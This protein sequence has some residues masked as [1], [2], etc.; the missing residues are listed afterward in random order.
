M[1]PGAGWDASG[2]GTAATPPY[3]ASSAWRSPVPYLFGGLAAMLGLIAFALLV[4]FCS[5]RQLSGFLESGGEANG[6]PDSDEEAPSDG[7]DATKPPLLFEDSIV[8]IMAGDRKPTFLATPMSS[9]AAS[10]TDKVDEAGNDGKEAGSTATSPRSILESNRRQN[11]LIG[12]KYRDSAVTLVTPQCF[13]Y[14]SKNHQHF[15]CSSRVQSSCYEPPSGRTLRTLTWTNL[16]Y[17]TS[18]SRNTRGPTWLDL[19]RVDLLL[20]L[21][22]SCRPKPA[23]ARFKRTNISLFS[24]QTVCQTDKKPRGNIAVKKLKSMNSKAE[25]EF[26]VEVE[27]LARVRHKNLL[28]LRG[29]CVVTDQRLI[30]YD[31]MPNLSLVSH[32]HGQYAHEVRLD[33]RRRMNVIL[34]SAEALV[35]LHHEVTPHIIHRDIKA[36][37]V[38]LDANFE[39]LVADFGFAKL[40]PE[41]VSHMTTRVKGTL[42]YL[43]PEY[44]MWGRVSDSCDVY[45]FGILLLELVSGRKPIEKLP[46][47]MK[48]TITEWAEPLISKGRFREVVDPRLRGNFD[49]DELRRVVEAAV[50]CIQGEAEQR[51][52]MKEVVGILMGREV[53]EPKMEAVRLKSIRYGEHLTTMDQSSDEGFDDSVDAGVGGGGRGGSVGDESGLY[54]VFGAMEVQK[55]HDPY[56]KHAPSAKILVGVSLDARASFQLLSWA[57]TVAAHPNDTVVALHV[58]GAVPV[59][60]KD[61]PRKRHRSRP[62]SLF[63]VDRGIRRPKEA[64]IHATDNSSSSS[65]WTSNH[66]VRAVSPFHKLFCSIS[67]PER[68]HSPRESICEK[69][70]PRG[71]LEGPDA[72]SPVVAEDCSS[73]PSSVTGRRSSANMWR[74]SSVMKLLFSLPRSSGESISKES[75]A[76]SSYTDDLKP[77][78][79]CFTYEEISRGSL[80]NGR[81]VAVKRLTKGNGD[82]QKEKEFL[83]ELGILGHVCHPNAANLIGCCI[84]NGLH[85]VFDLSC[86]GSLASAL[87]SEASAS[88][89]SSSSSPSP[90]HRIIHR[91][92]K[93]SNVLLGPDLEPQISDFGLAKWLPKQWT[94]HSVIP[95]EGTFGYLA[96]EYFMHGIVDEKTDVFAFGV[97]L[98]EIVTGRRPVDAS[99]QNLLLW[100]TPLIESGR[101]AELADPK[102][103]DE[104]DKSQL[105]RLVLTAS[106]CV[107]QSS[108]W[109]PSMGE[110]SE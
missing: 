14:Y 26:A 82:R 61:S 20:S 3:P 94:H 79:R 96:P 38:L 52:D 87:H 56:A 103:E 46:G 13:C 23:Q 4:L 74:R 88:A 92:I 45:S 76:C 55:M 72:G 67:K 101:I 59:W 75:D 57:V 71:V 65:R 19:V 41:G 106:Y 29:Y 86:N 70:S 8:V 15:E 58:L 24:L 35:Y 5:F 7:G 43:A 84:E 39:P 80:Y 47:G 25:M 77:S 11:C 108:I 100:A 85:L 81:S 53:R 18:K 51:P 78:W 21:S 40:V 50:L 17:G 97:L 48:R 27:V 89:T 104:Y 98:L 44:A 93:A 49:G 107:R 109:R 2:G 31:Y 90:L 91:D 63:S 30:V 64:S 37:N 68:R 32:L 73:P 33:W 36:S 22:L 28:G 102:L 16:S 99:K 66:M 95:I 83:I 60:G 42:G 54:G 1:R 69:D 9:R 62:T 110:V 105:Q 6:G 10:F 34:G 12:S